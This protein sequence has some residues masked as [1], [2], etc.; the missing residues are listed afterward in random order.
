MHALPF[1]GLRFPIWCLITLVLAACQASGTVERHGG[2]AAFNER[3][4]PMVFDARTLV[5]GNHAG[6]VAQVMND[7]RDMGFALVERDRGAQ[8][9]EDTRSDVKP[10]APSENEF[11]RR[12]FLAGAE[13]LVIVRIDGS[14]QIPAVRVTGIDVE[15][16]T[17]LWMG[18]V[19][20]SQPVAES[21]YHRRLIEFA[22][23]ALIEG[24][25]SSDGGTTGGFSHQ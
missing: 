4:G 15:N 2:P 16:G 1:R 20:S 12:G 22:R 7:L 17:I 6:S 11:L 13:M 14:R 18:G 25:T 23:Q 8:I 24:M 3:T 10:A 19:A 9:L 21:D 5:I